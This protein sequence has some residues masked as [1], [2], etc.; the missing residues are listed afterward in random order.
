MPPQEDVVPSAELEATNIGVVRSLLGCLNAADVSGA[1]AFIAEDVVDHNPAA[2]LRGREG[3]LLLHGKILHKAFPDMQV[4]H[5]AILA[6]GEMVVTRVH[7]RATSVGPFM[8]IPPTGGVITA[9]GLEMYRLAE[10]MIVE[11]WAQFDLMAILR[12]LGAIIALP[13]GP[14]TG[15]PPPATP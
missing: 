12:Q 10:G 4:E 3:F 14:P 5:E 15:G 2:P 8:G 9:A 6:H 7:M 13:V 11:H 1:A